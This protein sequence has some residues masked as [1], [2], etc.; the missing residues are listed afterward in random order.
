MGQILPKQ[1]ISKYHILFVKNMVFDV[2]PHDPPGANFVGGGGGTF[3]GKTT[4]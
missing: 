1:V 4:R 2:A 3:L